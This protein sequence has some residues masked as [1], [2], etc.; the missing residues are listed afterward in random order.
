MQE[1]RSATLIGIHVE[2]G[3]YKYGEVESPVTMMLSVQETEQVVTILQRCCFLTE[4]KI[5][6]RDWQ[7]KEGATVSSFLCVKIIFLPFIADEVWLLD[8]YLVPRRSG[9]FF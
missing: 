8:R 9:Y 3:M 4:I 1:R 7:Q 5:I 2:L 6:N